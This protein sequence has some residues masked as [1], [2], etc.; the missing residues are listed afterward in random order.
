[1]GSASL[2]GNEPP[3][4]RPAAR[5]LRA[6]ADHFHLRQGEVAELLERL[7]FG[8]LEGPNLPEVWRRPL[9]RRAVEAYAAR[10]RAVARL[11]RRGAL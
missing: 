3:P 10:R 8:E 5:R 1:M 2:P 7:P 4:S 9:A 6:L 11:A